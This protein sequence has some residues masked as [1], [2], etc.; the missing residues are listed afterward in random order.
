MNSNLADKESIQQAASQPQPKSWRGFTLIE[1]LVVIAIIAIL[2]ALLLPALNAA[3]AKSWRVSCASN[4]KQIGSATLV[5]AGDND[6][7][8]PL[9]SWKDCPPSTGNPWQTAEACRMQAAGSHVVVEGPYGLGLLWFSNDIQ[10][11][12]V[13]YCPAVLSGN[14]CYSTYAE[15]GWPWPSIPS[16]YTGANA[17][18]RCGYNF[19]PQSRTTQN[20]SSSYGT[21][22]QILPTLTA[23]SIVLTGPYPGDPAQSSK[24]YPV[25]FKTT[26][27]NQSK[28]MACDALTTFQGIPHQ[29]NGVPAGDNVLFGDGHVKFVT[30]NGNNGINT[31]SPYDPALWDPID[32]NGAG[33]CNDPV[34]FRII[35]N[36]F[37]P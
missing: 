1:L 24:N 16:D 4:E 26:D 23:K 32:V 22:N 7:Y 19:Y 12:Q 5:Y 3:K 29:A 6:D 35:F 37:L 9:T 28:A 31:L 17:Y 15:P 36:A 8:L 34:G 18:V 25:A 30:V 10:D 20:V 13:L 27:M 2:A 14:Y 33:P 21:G 11:P